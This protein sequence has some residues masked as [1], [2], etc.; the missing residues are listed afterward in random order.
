MKTGTAI[1]HIGDVEDVMAW[2]HGYRAQPF[3]RRLDRALLAEGHEIYATNCASCHGTYDENI[4]TPSLVSFPNKSADVGSDRRRLKLFGQEV[5]DAVNESVI[6][7]FILA[8]TVTEYAVPPL[9][10]L[11]SSAPYF[12]NGSVPTLRALMY[13]EE[14]PVKF[15]VGGHAIDLDSVGVAGAVG[16]DGEW[17]YPAD[18][19]PWSIPAEVDSTAY[20][21]GNEGHEAEFAMLN[22]EEKRALL[23]YL[24]AL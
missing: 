7:S 13:P 4:D 6:G 23:E 14:R 5:A 11:W 20:G 8:K 17:H 9:T 21:L 10:G 18:V 24:K 3:P 2:M 22:D 19:T 16:A 1:S 12:H 15:Q